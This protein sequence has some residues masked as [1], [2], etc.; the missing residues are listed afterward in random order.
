[1]SK[2]PQLLA[3]SLSSVTPPLLSDSDLPPGGSKRSGLIK[4][5]LKL[6]AAISLKIMLTFQWD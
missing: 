6:A 2:R 1:M 4:G 5:L 3:S